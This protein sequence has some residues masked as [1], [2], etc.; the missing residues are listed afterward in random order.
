MMTPERTGQTLYKHKIVKR[1]IIIAIL[2]IVNGLPSIGGLPEGKPS[3]RIAAMGGLGV[4]IPDEWSLFHNQAGM[5][6]IGYP[7]VGAHHENRFI[8][9]DLSFSSLGVIYPV[10]PG[11]L[12]FS[13]K[14]LGFSEFS[15]TKAGLS[16]GMKLS[17][18]FSAG[19]QMSIH[20]IYAKGEYGQTSSFTAE[21]GIM[22]SPTNN[23]TIGAHVINP[24]RSK[25]N[26]DNRIPTIFNL[27]A[28]Y[29]LGNSVLIT[30]GAEKN[31]E[32]KPNLKF[33]IEYEP[34]ENLFFRTGIATEPNLIGFGMGYQF[35]NIR[36]D[37]AFSRHEYLGYTPHISVSYQFT[38]RNKTIE[39]EKTAP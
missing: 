13:V 25:I 3:S 38:K 33:G 23:L 19:V 11:A 18:R 9:P 5:A 24:T 7:W 21:G 28:A 1:S 32:Y 16:Y 6:F 20:N 17:P 31:I 14:R 8:S 29:K 10:R 26:K 12:G 34:L 37:I 4:A 30:A 22:Y 2:L 35:G 36:M 15:Q 27:G 39:V